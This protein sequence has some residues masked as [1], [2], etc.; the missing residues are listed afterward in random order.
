MNYLNTFVT[1]YRTEK[2]RKDV[3]FWDQR[4]LEAKNK[5]YNTQAKKAQYSDQFAAPTIRFQSIDIRREKIESDYRVAFSFY[6]Q[7][8]QQYE[9]AK[10]KVQ[11]E[12]PVFKTLQ[13]P[14]IP[15]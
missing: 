1:N 15:Y 13:Q 5:Y 12:T 14:V 2:T 8:L 7:L 11:Q 9:N 6:Q 3:N 4:L 10:L